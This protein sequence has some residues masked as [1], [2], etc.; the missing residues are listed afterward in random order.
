[1]M[2]YIKRASPKVKVWCTFNVTPAV[3]RNSKDK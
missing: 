3:K 2:S 1:M